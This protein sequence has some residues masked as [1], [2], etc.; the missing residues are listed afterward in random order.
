MGQRT[1][2]LQQTLITI[3][4]GGGIMKASII[5]PV[6]NREKYVHEATMSILEQTMEYLEGFCSE[7]DRKIGN[8]IARS[9]KEHA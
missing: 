1:F 5:M 7:T 6:Y 9:E 3:K 4:A 2:F 8:L